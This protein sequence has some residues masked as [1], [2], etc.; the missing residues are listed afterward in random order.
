[1]SNG[2]DALIEGVEP[3]YGV[4]LIEFKLGR[5]GKGEA[6]QGLLWSLV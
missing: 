6:M 2:F 5:L 4:L 3:L 1:M